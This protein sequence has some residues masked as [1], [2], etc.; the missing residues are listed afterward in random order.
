MMKTWELV[1][2][3]VWF[4]YDDL[5]SNILSRPKLVGLVCYHFGEN[6]DSE[7]IIYHFSAMQSINQCYHGIFFL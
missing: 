7:Y 2:N 5:K 1:F 3:T 4:R 6:S